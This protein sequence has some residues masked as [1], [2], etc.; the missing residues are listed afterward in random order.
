MWY[1]F[2]VVN[3][4]NNHRVDLGVYARAG[5]DVENLN[6]Y[7]LPLDGKVAYVRENE[8]RAG[9]VRFQLWSEF[10][11][12]GLVKEAAVAEVVTFLGPSFSEIF[13]L[14]MEGVLE[15]AKT[16]RE[17]SAGEV[18]KMENVLNEFELREDMKFL[19]KQ[20]RLVRM[21]F[22]ARTTDE[23]QQVINLSYEIAADSVNSEVMLLI[24][25]ASSFRD[26]FKD[27]PGLEV[28]EPDMRMYVKDE[29]RRIN[30]WMELVN[31][32]LK[33]LH[34]GKIKPK[35]LKLLT[36]D[37][38]MGAGWQ[39]YSVTEGE[40]L[41]G[42]VSMVVVNMN[43]YAKEQ[44]DICK[45][46]GIKTT[47]Q[48]AWLV[49]TF[50]FVAH[51]L[52]HAYFW[53]GEESRLGKEFEEYCADCLATF[54]VLFRLRDEEGLG[55]EELK[56]LL[57]GLFV[58]YTQSSSELKRLK[59]E[60]PEAWWYGLSAN[61]ISKVLLNPDLSREQMLDQLLND[62]K[63]L[64]IADKEACQEVLSG[65]VGKDQWVKLTELR[66]KIGLEIG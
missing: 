53:E 66:R 28:C 41:S 20:F 4:E 42:D 16:W 9:K 54:I 34:A 58:R 57:E 59:N 37:Y 7:N 2:P 8:K 6:Q 5:I 1:I 24:P 48:K 55:F 23:F 38:V 60:E 26:N 3:S 46:L 44:V 36:V 45:E 49:K 64:L 14:M 19:N 32:D 52:A 65:R 31:E 12:R 51:E 15:P 17:Y 13:A 50:D 56:A 35:D 30:D 27:V 61:R 63:R 33:V 43:K 18:R 21:L 62:H 39:M 25:V 22:D 10:K 29:D 11:E 47:E 40:L